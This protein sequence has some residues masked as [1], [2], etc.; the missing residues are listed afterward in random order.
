[1]KKTKLHFLEIKLLWNCF[2]CAAANLLTILPIKKLGSK[3][4]YAIYRDGTPK[5]KKIKAVK[6]DGRKITVVCKNCGEKRSGTINFEHST[7][8]F[9]IMEKLRKARIRRNKK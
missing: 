1:M 8:N 4:K 3:T 7:M 6:L 2:T 9:K 5:P